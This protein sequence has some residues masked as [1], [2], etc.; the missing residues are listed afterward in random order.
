MPPPKQLYRR[1]TEGAGA[2]TDC[3]KT[4]D[5]WTTEGAGAFRP[6]N[7]A[8]ISMAFRPGL[9]RLRKIPS[10]KPL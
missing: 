3:G 4:H 2:F 7:T 1:A 9:Y 6:L 5:K 10:A 8:A